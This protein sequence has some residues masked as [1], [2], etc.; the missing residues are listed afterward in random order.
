[1][2]KSRLIFI[3]SI[4]EDNRH[5]KEKALIRKVEQ[6][7]VRKTFVDMD[8]LRTSVYASLVRYL[9]EKKRKNIS[10][11]NRLMRPAIME[12]HWRIWMKAK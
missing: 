7:I 5:P 11:G 9:E 12:R 2:H 8:G 4:D 6:D 1:M 10:D 3:K